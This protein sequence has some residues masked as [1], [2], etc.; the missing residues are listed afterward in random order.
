MNFEATF[1]D[2]SSGVAFLQIGTVS[3]M[4][5]EKFEQSKFGF[6]FIAY[7]A[8]DVTDSPAIIFQLHGAG[9]RGSGG[10]D[11]DKVLVN[12]FANI[13]DCDEFSNCVLVMPQCPFDSFWVAKI[14]SLKKFIDGVVEY[15]H[16]DK[17]RIS[18]TGMSMGG[19]GTWYTA[20]A[21]PDIFCAIAPCCGGGMPWNAEVLKMPVWAFHGDCDD[22]VLASNSVDMVDS[23]KKTN[24]NV[25]LDIYSGVG[26]N[27]WEKAFSKDLLLWLLQQHK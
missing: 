18:L 26:H 20:M 24:D 4:K 2:Y 9:E 6:P 13:L 1:G 7:I 22:V 10:E 12:G 25:R 19:F 23:L 15:Y 5:T 11:L 17:K 21:Y 14:E 27:S 3:I 16:A 8:D